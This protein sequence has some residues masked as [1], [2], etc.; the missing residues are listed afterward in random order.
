MVC[1][2]QGSRRVGEEEFRRLYRGENHFPVMFFGF[3]SSFLPMDA[4]SGASVI[5]LTCD[6]SSVSIRYRKPGKGIV[7]KV[8]PFSHVRPQGLFGTASGAI[9][10]RQL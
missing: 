5:S 3:F 8:Q 4:I 1:Y 9:S 2:Q 6:F 10:S 7:A